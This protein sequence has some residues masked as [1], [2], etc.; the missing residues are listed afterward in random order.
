MALIIYAIGILILLDYLNV[1]I[2]PILAGLGIGGLAIAL[3]LQPTLGNFFAGTQIVSDRVVRTGDYIELDNSSIRG[4]VTDVGW[5]STRIRTPFDNL[6][7]IPNS[8]LADS[9][10]TN[11]Y[12]PNMELGVIVNC[13]VSYSSDLAHVEDVAWGSQNGASVRPIPSI[14]SVVPHRPY[15]SAGKHR[16]HATYPPG[17]RTS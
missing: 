12:A 4:Y 6:V 3:A 17:S 8:R 9:I 1:S 10:I 16:W 14:S 15:L 7:T 13:G 2:T 11:Y 5:R